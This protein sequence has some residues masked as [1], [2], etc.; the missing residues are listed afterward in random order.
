MRIDL[1]YVILSTIAAKSSQHRVYILRNNLMTLRF[2]VC[3]ALFMLAMISAVQNAEAQAKPTG[4]SKADPSIVGSDKTPPA[5]S[6]TWQL[7]L[8]LKTKGSVK[9]FICGAT[10]IDHDLVVTA[11]H[12]LEKDLQGNR[13][14]KFE[15]VV[16][17]Q[18]TNLYDVQYQNVTNLVAHSEYQSTGLRSDVALLKIEKSFTSAIPISIPTNESEKIIWALPEV[19]FDVFGW[20]KKETNGEISPVLLTAALSAVSIEAC[21]GAD[22]Y[23]GALFAESGCVASSGKGTCQGDSGGPVVYAGNGI[24]TLIGVI[25]AAEGCA[26][27][28]RPTI[29]TRLVPFVPWINKVKQDWGCTPQDIQNNKC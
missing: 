17:G 18:A 3:V 20:G 13:Y 4:I 16:F 19:Q 22:M 2:N 6:V 27:A 24:K 29:F 23:A 25:S 26:K 7:G 12:C 11:A 10:L 14:E 15:I 1:G 5:A 9:G 21:N 28:G 8:A